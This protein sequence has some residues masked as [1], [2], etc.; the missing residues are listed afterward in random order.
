[1]F[2]WGL[3]IA[4]VKDLSRP[5]EKLSLS[6]NIGYLP[7]NNSDR[8]ADEETQR[9]KQAKGNTIQLLTYFLSLSIFNTPDH[10]II[11]IIVDNSDQLLVS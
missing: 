1:M 11:I 3:V 2:K 4:G 10:P 9:D 7:E 5:A 6:Q 8:R